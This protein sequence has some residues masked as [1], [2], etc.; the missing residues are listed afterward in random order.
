MMYMRNWAANYELSDY[1]CVPS[2]FAKQSF[3]NKGFS[4]KKLKKINYGVS[5][6]EFSN[7]GKRNKNKE[8]NIIYVGSISVR[9]GVIYLIKAFNELK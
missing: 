5:L 7:H 2:E 1:I 9:K 8:F 6:N 4:S 3:I